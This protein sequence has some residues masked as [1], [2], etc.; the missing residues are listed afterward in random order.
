MELTPALALLLSLLALAAGALLA[1]GL[2]RRAGVLSA[3]DGFVL[4]SVAGLCLLFLFPE[5]LL[6]LGPGALVWTALGL[7]LPWASERLLVGRRE[8]TSRGILVAALLALLLHQAVDGVGLGHAGHDHDHD[9]GETWVARALAIVIHQLPVGLLLGGAL[10]PLFGRLGT[11]AAVALLLLA[12]LGGFAFGS[13]ILPPAAT[14]ALNALLAGAL[15]HIV[16]D[17]AP[18]QAP[19]PT[20]ARAA[21]A[22]ALAALLLLALLPLHPPEPVEAALAGGA[23]LLQAAS[24]PVLVGF[25][26]A[27][28]LA[29]IPPAPLIARMQGGSGL[30]SAARGV[31]FGLP[32]PL[33]ACGV[34]P[35][36]RQLGLA[37]VGPTAA[38]AFLLAAP[39][40]GPDALLLSFPLLGPELALLRA[41][42]AVVL[43]LAA[44]L[45][46]SRLP[47]GTS[48][49]PC[50]P[51]PAPSGGA[52]RVLRA[53]LV[54]AVDDLGPWILAG[55]VAAAL[56]GPWIQPGWAERIDP[57]L[58]VPLLALL[59]LPLYG[60]G[61]AAIPAAAVLLQEGFSPGAAL[62]LLLTGP[63]VNLTAWRALREV[64][65]PRGAALLLGLVL[66]GVVA[67]GWV[68]DLLLPR[69]GA[70]V[71]GDP[72]RAGQVAAAAFALLLGAS[73]L[74]QGPRGFLARLG[75][76][77]AHRHG[78]AHEHDLAHERACQL[79]ACDAPPAR[80]HDHDHDHGHER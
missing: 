69:R 75:V 44:G 16:V 50:P 25:A 63:A 9:H 22:G 78:E 65:G 4:V 71:V 31:L 64:H 10:V 52:A 30:A 33:C 2:P 21:G 53:A 73:L 5:A 70:T 58:Q 28:G 41:G 48:P 42:G 15:L 47:Q 74:R 79:A 13:E 55:L 59:S 34:G 27:G 19:G 26:V 40:L 60:A 57:A 6:A 12:T 37:G 36:H 80:E 77:H 45:I 39:L 35:L 46:A 56:L 20:G 72:G 14:A 43:A 61:A 29:L 67:A 76:G 3:L 68:T 62:V 18:E 32:L 17:H 1:A 8:G 66:L 49:G 23:R 7:A 51:L 54:E 11:A 24:L 38:A